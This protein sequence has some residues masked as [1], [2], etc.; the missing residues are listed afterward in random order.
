MRLFIAGVSLNGERALSIRP[1]SPRRVGSGAACLLRQ[2]TAAL[3][4][5]A[6]GR[7]IVRSSSARRGLPTN[8]AATT[9]VCVRYTAEDAL[10]LETRDRRKASGLEPASDRKA[11]LIDQVCISSF[12]SAC[13]ILPELAS[14]VC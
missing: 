3:P 12:A 13:Q 1:P 8:T 5:R 2:F 11:W 6:P 4:R 9:A 14:G 7:S 10:L